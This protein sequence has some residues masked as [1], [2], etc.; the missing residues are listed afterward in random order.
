[1][2]INWLKVE[3]PGIIPVFWFTFIF[4][5]GFYFLACRSFHPQYYR[6]KLR[7]AKL[8]LYDEMTSVKKY[9]VTTWSDGTKTSDYNAQVAGG[10]ILLAIFS[11]LNIVIMPLT[12]FYCMI[13]FYLMPILKK[14]TR[15][16]EYADW[17]SERAEIIAQG[18][19]V[20]DGYAADDLDEIISIASLYWEQKEYKKAYI[21]LEKAAEYG[22][23]RSQYLTGIAYYN[24]EY[25]AGSN[26]KYTYWV[27]KA[28]VQGYP[29]AMKE[30]NEIGTSASAP[31]PPS[32]PVGASLCL[33]CGASLSGRGKFCAG[34][35]AE[36]YS[37]EVS[38]TAGQNEEENLAAPGQAE[39]NAFS[40]PVIEGLTIMINKHSYA[41]KENIKVRV[42][43]VPQYVADGLGFTAIYEQGAR[44]ENYGK[45]KYLDAGDALYELKAPKAAGNYEMRVYKEDLVY[46]DENLVARV[47]FT[48]V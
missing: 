17:L 33:A 46:T 38:G 30:L 1:M 36:A 27:R 34:C 6:A 41:V 26:E 44:H 2:L 13:K 7:G 45:F 15:W 3:M 8:A 35:G 23:A 12:T 37:A 16:R 43:G 24:G 39:M 18:P 10:N 20:E 40:S 42:T 21:C 19:F 48:V 47:G 14:K 5:F 22:D 9:T 11:I 32:A 4:G 29:D 31:V 25:V 28:A